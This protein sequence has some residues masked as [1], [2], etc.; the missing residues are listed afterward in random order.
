MGVMEEVSVWRECQKDSEESAMEQSGPSPV[1]TMDRFMGDHI[2]M[3]RSGRW[4]VVIGLGM[5]SCD[6]FRAIGLWC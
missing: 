6:Y 5:E 4:V 1:M 3:E 2:W